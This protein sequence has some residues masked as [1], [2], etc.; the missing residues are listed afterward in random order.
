MA[1]Q[2]AMQSRQSACWG[3]ETS[4]SL[5]PLPAC[6]SA[7]AARQAEA[8]PPSLLS[9]VPLQGGVQGLASSVGRAATA[10]S[11]S[12]AMKSGSGCVAALHTA[13]AGPPAGRRTPVMEV[14]AFVQAAP[15]AQ[16]SPAPWRREA[17][18]RARPSCA[19]PTDAL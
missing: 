2:A 5:P 4:W 18:G 7:A 16:E 13:P 17:Q 12:A 8:L 14:V 3:T 9:S 6:F 1:L 11:P 19:K 10:A 15:Q